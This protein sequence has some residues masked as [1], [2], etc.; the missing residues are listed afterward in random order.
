MT[1]FAPTHTLKLSPC[2]IQT[3]P[4]VPSNTL[5][6]WLRRRTK[7]QATVDASTS[8]K[9]ST[10]SLQWLQQQQQGRFD[11]E[12]QLLF[13]DIL[14][15]S[16]RGDLVT[17]PWIQG[18]MLCLLKE[19]KPVGWINFK[20][21]QGWRQKF[22]ERFDLVFR[23]TTNTKQYTVEERLPAV[24][25]FYKYF[26]K[27]C[28]DGVHVSKIYGVY[29]LEVRLHVD[30]VPFELGGVL[31]KTITVKGTK[32]VQVCNPLARIDVRQGSLMLS[33][34]ADGRI[35]PVGLCVTRTP[36]TI[37]GQDPLLKT[38]HAHRPTK[39]SNS[40]SPT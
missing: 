25:K 6:G 13:A 30:E 5:R 37:G 40:C 22:F 1:T 10:R 23:A 21:S 32:R 36:T 31:D 12:E 35:G 16:L 39:S 9:K 17:V 15:A 18:S 26:Q 27:V 4:A 11:E 38:K 2:S 8:E 20:A 24:I 33:F 28:L 7:I 29:P 14:A 3:T 34:F 19:R